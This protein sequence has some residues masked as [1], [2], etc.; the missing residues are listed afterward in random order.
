MTGGMAEMSPAS[1]YFLPQYWE[2]AECLMLASETI[3]RPKLGKAKLAS[4][5]Y[6]GHMCHLMDLTGLRSQTQLDSRPKCPEA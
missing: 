3:Q 2:A 4:G 5:R 1:L 6:H